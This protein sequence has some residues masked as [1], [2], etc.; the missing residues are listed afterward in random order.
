V[1]EFRSAK[2]RLQDLA[3]IDP[4]INFYA[5]KALVNN[6]NLDQAMIEIIESQHKQISELKSEA[7]S[8][9]YGF[10]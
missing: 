1:G 2:T 4:L 6:E 5:N 8:K 9:V 10:R 3:M 7:K